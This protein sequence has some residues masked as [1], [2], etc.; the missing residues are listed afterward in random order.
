MNFISTFP[1]FVPKEVKAINELIKKNLGQKED[2]TQV[3][4]N[5]NKTGEFFNVPISPIMNLIHP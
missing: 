4:K 5:V 1:C 3:A 2:A